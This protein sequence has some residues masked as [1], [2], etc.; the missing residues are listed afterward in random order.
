MLSTTG[1]DAAAALT[2][3]DVFLCDES[4]CAAFAA[5]LFNLVVYKL[6]ASSMRGRCASVYHRMVMEVRW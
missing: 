4:R 6:R 3:A 1:A 5:K 2:V